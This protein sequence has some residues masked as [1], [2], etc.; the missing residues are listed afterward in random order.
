MNSVNTPE[1]IE[2][3][4]KQVINSLYGDDVSDFRVNETFNIKEERYTDRFD[5]QV[6]FM[7]ND[8]KHTV[9]LEIEKE[10]GRVVKA[11][12]MDAMKPL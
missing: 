5:I 7:Q 3:A 9:D 4:S 12:L 6:N 8:L 11:L 10:T 2:Q 1:E